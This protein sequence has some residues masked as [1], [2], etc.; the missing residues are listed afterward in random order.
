M[1]QKYAYL[2]MLKWASRAV[3]SSTDLI[4]I[5]L[6]RCHFRF[7][8]VIV[9]GPVETLMLPTNT[10]V[11]LILSYSKQ[12]SKARAE[13]SNERTKTQKVK[14]IQRQSMLSLICLE[15]LTFINHFPGKTLTWV[16][17]D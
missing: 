12:F 4:F 1:I 6:S 3:A 11:G 14:V 10:E 17:R 2:K 7:P 15:W 9:A 16:K 13:L 8:P 5:L